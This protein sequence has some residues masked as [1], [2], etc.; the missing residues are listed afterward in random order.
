MLALLKLI[1]YYVIIITFYASDCCIQN[2]Y[3]QLDLYVLVCTLMCLH[4][5]VSVY[6]CACTF[7]ST[8]CTCMYVCGRA[9]MHVICAFRDTYILHNI[10]Y[11]A[12]TWPLS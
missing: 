9:C 3:V 6:T 4:A 8:T 5:H 11:C 10:V 7:N 1:Q 12:S 2:I